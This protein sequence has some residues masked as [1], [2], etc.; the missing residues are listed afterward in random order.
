MWVGNGS[1]S[2]YSSCQE[3]NV[4]MNMIICFKVELHTTTN[5]Y[6]T[7]S[8]WHRVSHGTKVAQRYCSP[9]TAAARPKKGGVYGNLGKGQKV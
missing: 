4:W 2:K 7:G 5:P 1:V 8:R 9:G 6:N 3:S